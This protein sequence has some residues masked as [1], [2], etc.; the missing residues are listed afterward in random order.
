MTI[1]LA[2]FATSVPPPIAKPTSACLRA[3][4][5]FTPS[6]V[7]PTTRF[8]DLAI[9]TRRLLSLGRA[10]ATTRN[11]GSIPTISSSLLAASSS[12]VITTS[13]ADFTRPHSLAIAAAVSRRS[14]VIITTCTPARRTSSSAVIDSGLTSSRIPTT[15][16][17]VHSPSGRLPF[18]NGADVVATASRRIALPANS[19]S[20]ALSMSV[21]SGWT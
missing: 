21:I 8:R 17:S 4:E 7:M 19:S 3:G 11:R 14:P 15:P 12:E 10:R 16:T 18:S 9:R 5:S 1:S 13:S 20:L 6:P 2:S